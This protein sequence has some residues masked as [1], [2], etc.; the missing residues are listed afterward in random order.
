MPSEMPESHKQQAAFYKKAHGKSPDVFFVYASPKEDGKPMPYQ[1]HKLS[2]E[3][4]KK[5]L[6]DMKDSIKRMA[7]FLRLSDNPFVLVDAMPHNKGSFFWT[8]EPKTLDEIVAE[9]KLAIE[10]TEEK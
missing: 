4:Y 7:N 5:S 1:I 9:K 10:N 3:D 6:A 2:D 8:S